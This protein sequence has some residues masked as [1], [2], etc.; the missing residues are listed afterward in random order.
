MS[1]MDSDVDGMRERFAAIQRRVAAAA[2]RGGRAASDVLV[3]GAC[4][5]MPP[6]LLAAALAAGVR[7][8]GENRLQE[9]VEHRAAMAAS[10]A[11][12]PS[13]QFHFIGALQTNKARKAA[14]MCSLIHSVDRLALADV[15]DRYGQQRGRAVSILIEVNVSRE[16]SKSGVLPEELGSLSR[17][18]A[19]RDGI[20]VAGLMCIPAP[21]DDPTGARAPFARMRQLLREM[22]ESGVFALPPQELSMGMSGDFELAI[23]EGATMVRIGTALFGARG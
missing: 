21:S 13:V 20:I 19:T 8:F 18:L 22:R 2:A 12:D 1:V 16:A 3:I 5:T 17:H 4:K 23:E 10:L 11:A 14:E 6:A 15:L 7:I 9:L